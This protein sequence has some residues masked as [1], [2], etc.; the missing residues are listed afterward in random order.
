MGNMVWNDVVKFQS[1][2][3]LA[4]RES[5][6]TWGEVLRAFPEAGMNANVRREVLNRLARKMTPVETARPYP[7]LRHFTRD[8]KSYTLHPTKGW[9][10]E[11]L[12]PHR[13]R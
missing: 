3:T 12:T 13:M 2:N 10:S 5:V 6:E 11:R 7:V 9:K 4:S 1:R 8:G